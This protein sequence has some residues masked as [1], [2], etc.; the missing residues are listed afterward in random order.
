MYPNPLIIKHSGVYVKMLPGDLTH[1]EAFELGPDLLVEWAIIEVDN[2]G[3]DTMDMRGNWAVSLTRL[4]LFLTDEEDC[5]Q[6]HYSWDGD[7][8]VS[9]DNPQIYLKKRG[10]VNDLSRPFYF[11]YR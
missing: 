9:E 8:W 2:D 6:Q 11:D 5:F 7:K 4:S 1:T 3:I 10:D